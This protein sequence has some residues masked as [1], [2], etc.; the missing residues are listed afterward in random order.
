MA[1]NGDGIERSGIMSLNRLAGRGGY[2]IGER[3]MPC[4]VV[5][6]DHF[7]SG[8]QR[9]TRQGNLLDGAVVVLDRQDRVRDGNRQGEKREVQV[10]AAGACRNRRL[11]RSVVVERDDD[12]RFRGGRTL[13]SVGPGNG[14]TVT[15]ITGDVHTVAARDVRRGGQ[16]HLAH[17]VGRTVVRQFQL[18]LESRHDRGEGKGDGGLRVLGVVR[19]GDHIGLGHVRKVLALGRIPGGRL[20]VR[21]NETVHSSVQIPARRD[22]AEGK[23]V[24]TVWRRIDTEKLVRVAIGPL[25]GAGA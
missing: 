21:D 19:I 18:E 4:P 25:Q 20:V 1:V 7:L 13:G 9:E 24:A 17:R 22:C 10:G 16:L 14:L 12:G 6:H 5:G 2:L 15:V 23:P 3:I 8:S 11:R